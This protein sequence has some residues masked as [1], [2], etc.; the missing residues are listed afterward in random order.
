VDWSKFVPLLDG[1]RQPCHSWLRQ[2]GALALFIGCNFFNS[3]VATGHTFFSVSEPK[4]EP[5]SSIES[6]NKIEF[7]E[8]IKSDSPS[9]EFV[10]LTGTE[11]CD[12]FV[13]KLQDG[14][15]TPRR[16]FKPIDRF[17]IGDQVGDQRMFSDFYIH[18][19]GSIIGR[20]LT[21]IV[22][23]KIELWRQVVS[24]MSRDCNRKIS[25]QLPFSGLF[26]ASYQITRSAPQKDSGKSENNRECGND[27]FGVV[28]KKI[29][30]AITVYRELRRE[31]GNIFFEI[32]GCW[33][34]IYLLNACLKRLGT[35][36]DQSNDR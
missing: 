9:I 17:S 25:P 34:V 18:P 36:N 8:N 29:P 10:T 21:A 6:I 3:E 32:L 15:I 24:T 27:C 26:R 30:E 7:P 12:V 4:F 33:I 19:T 2:A 28:V 23:Q 16:H 11:T 35:C 13:V 22:G 14:E 1:L 5:M 20:R 31:R